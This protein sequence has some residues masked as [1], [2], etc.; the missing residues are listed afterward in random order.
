MFSVLFCSFRE[1]FC[2]FHMSTGFLFSLKWHR[3]KASVA[4]RRWVCLGSLPLPSAVVFILG[5][6]GPVKFRLKHHSCMG[7]GRVR[8]FWRDKVPHKHLLSWICRWHLASKAGTFVMR[9]EEFQVIWDG[10]VHPL[11][12]HCGVG[13]CRPHHHG[14]VQWVANPGGTPESVWMEEECQCFL[15][16]VRLVLTSIPLAVPLISRGVLWMYLCVC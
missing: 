13:S 2:G 11:S 7:A 14:D 1:I 15:R 9:L 8:W 4:A 16:G 10:G 5:T 12:L 3:S 6:G